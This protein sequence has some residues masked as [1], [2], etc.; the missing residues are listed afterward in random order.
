MRGFLV[1]DKPEGVSSHH[2]VAVFRALLGKPKTGHTGTLDPFATGV[3]V[4]AFGTYTRLISFLPEETKTYLALLRLGEKTIT[5]DT[6]GEIVLRSELPSISEDEIDVVLSSMEGAQEQTP[7]QFSAVKHKGRPLYSYARK[8]QRIEVAARPIHIHMLRRLEHHSDSLRFET[9]SSRGTYIRQLG[10]SI[11]ENMGTVGHLTALRRTKSGCF[12]IEE[13]L[14]MEEF[15][16]YATENPLWRETLSWE[17]KSKYDRC[18][19]H[20]LW[21]KLQPH[22][23]SVED[24]FSYMP[25]VAVSEQRCAKIKNGLPP[26]WIPEDIQ[27]GSLFWLAHKKSFI[28]LAQHDGEKI[29]LIRVLN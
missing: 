8:G 24:V 4:L 1:I 17:G 3:L 28:A 7:P 25:Q 21:E 13:A 20:E 19:P 26:L 9:V 22:L 15:S 23:R 18:A 16:M 2:I 10:E 11:A 29:Q 12:L 14:S 6:E 27:V 5:G